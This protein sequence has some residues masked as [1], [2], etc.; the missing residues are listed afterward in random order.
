MFIYYFYLFFSLRI[1]CLFIKSFFTSGLDLFVWE[2]KF[3]ILISFSFRKIWLTG[4][5]WFCWEGSIYC[6]LGCC[7]VVVH[8]AVRF[9]HTEVVNCRWF[10]HCI[11]HSSRSWGT[12]LFLLYWPVLWF[13]GYQ[14][15]F[16]FIVCRESIAIS[17]WSNSARVSPL[18]V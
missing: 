7:R 2:P 6:C 9:F 15:W 11:A 12:T 8:G 14:H 16:L 3:L 18:G 5:L 1:E 17:T 10:G 4:G 13:T